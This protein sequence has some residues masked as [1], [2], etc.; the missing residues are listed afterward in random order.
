MK[1]LKVC[2]D[3][4]SMFEDGLFEIDLFASDRVTAS[5]ESAFELADH[6]Y[7]N[8]VVALAG[9]NATGK[10]TALN[11][12]ELACRIVDGSPARGGGLPSTFPA[13]FD[14]PSKLKCVIWHAD[15]LYLLESVLQT[16]EGGDDGPELTFSDEVI[17]SLPAKA[18]KRSTLASWAEIEKL[19]SPLCDR[20]QMPDSWAALTPPDVSVAAA[21]LAKDFGHRIRAIALRDGGFRLTEQFNG[22]DDV[23]RVFDSGIEHLEVRDSGRAFVLTFTGR[24]PIT[25]S[26]R[27]LTE[28]L[29]SGTVR[30]LGLVQRA[31]R[32]LR[33]GGYLLVDEVENHLN[34]QLVTSCL[35]C[36][37][38]AGPTPTARRWFS[39]LTTRSSSITCTA[40]TTCSF[41][42]DATAVRAW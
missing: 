4:L 34:R 21:V 20:A 14:G 1:L 17:S 35:I 41:S 16:V 24:E 11:L 12:L 5:D 2:F 10:T 22:L 6:L 7:V 37:P 36:L 27:G 38:P 31:M 42:P 15:R 13:A 33:S 39:R 30:G 32:V 3:H 18:L 40:R 19:A 26:E 29:S 25:I 9:I 28:V 8:S 23:L